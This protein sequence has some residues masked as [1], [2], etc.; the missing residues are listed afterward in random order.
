MYSVIKDYRDNNELR[1]SFNELAEKTFGLDFEDWYRNGFWGDNY[2]PYSI[3][4]E[5]KVVANVSVNKTDML[6]DGVVKHFIQLGTVMTD[7][8]YRNH[9]L[10]RAIMEQIESDF[11]GKVDGAYLFGNDSVLEFYPKFGFKRAKEYQLSKKISKEELGSCEC[12]YRKVAMD[13]ETAWRQL[14]NAMNTTVFHGKLDMVNN[15][16]LIMFY[17]TNF[18]QESVYYNSDTD[19]YVIADIDGESVFIH[20]IFSSRL[21][22][23]NTVIR[24]FG[25]GIKEIILGFTPKEIEGFEVEEL[26]EADCTF[27][28]KGG[29]MDI[30]EKNRLR[31]PSLSHA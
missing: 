19:T 20:N 31:I 3:V 29:G 25:S 21:T 6:I 18:M 12:K 27:F 9:G 23:L 8:A 2:N 4:I 10:S 26:H 17:V 13:N 22:E 28:V 7:E 30:M 5:G 15:N 11:D 16:E 14:V 1:A 24:L